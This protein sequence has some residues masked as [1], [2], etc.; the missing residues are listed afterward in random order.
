MSRQGT[1][2]TACWFCSTEWLY[3]GVA[4]RCGLGEL[5]GSSLWTIGF[6]CFVSLWVR[7]RLSSFGLDTGRGAWDLLGV[8]M[9]LS[10][11]WGLSVCY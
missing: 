9:F 1:C 5:A 11:W 8:W 7:H 10:V 6:E 2:E 3:R 4:G